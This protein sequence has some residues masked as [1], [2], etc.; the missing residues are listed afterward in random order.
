MKMKRLAAII[1]AA[2]VLATSAVCLTA[3]GGGDTNNG[4]GTVVEDSVATSLAGTR[5]DI[6][7]MTV[8]GKVMSIDELEQLYGD[9]LDMYFSFTEST[10][11]SHLMGQEETTSYTYEN[12]VV[13][14]EGESTTIV[15]DSMT[16]VV[17]GQ[18]IMLQKSGSA[19]VIGGTDAP[20]GI[21]VTDSVQVEGVTWKITSITKDGI[22][23]VEMAIQQGMVNA[24]EL[25]CVFEDGI[26]TANLMGD[27]ITGDYTYENGVLTV[28]G[29]KGEVSSNSL[30]FYAEGARFE[31][32]R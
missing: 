14:I 1:A 26:V 11:T 2:M 30:V 22:D 3:C 6:T 9:D 23:V 4:A 32:T 28:D 27:K 29:V 13:T 24:D 17:D 31:M 18:T 5:W 21:Q 7:G 16:F 12:G 20:T 15:G 8:N 10:V 19:P 25:T